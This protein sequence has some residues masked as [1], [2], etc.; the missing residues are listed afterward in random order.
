[1]RFSIF[2]KSKF[3][4]YSLC[5]LAFCRATFR[6]LPTKTVFVL[7]PITLSSVLLLL[8]LAS[9]LPTVFYN[10]T[11]W[12]KYDRDKLWLVYTQIVPVI[13]EPPCICILSQWSQTIS[14]WV[15]PLYDPLSILG[16]PVEWHWQWS[17]ERSIPVPVCSPRIRTPWDWIRDSDQ[18]SVAKC[19][20]RGTLISLTFEYGTDR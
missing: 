12:F 19:L 16:P 8:F 3:R 6:V 13:F 5:L 9:F 15:S 2:Q 4:G 10:S 20:G 18:K 17:T 1:M 14:V 7:F 11:R